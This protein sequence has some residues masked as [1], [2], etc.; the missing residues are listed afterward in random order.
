MIELWCT[1][2]FGQLIIPPHHQVERYLSKSHSGVG[3][4]GDCGVLM[5]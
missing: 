1:L 4:G 5:L 3:V 2:E